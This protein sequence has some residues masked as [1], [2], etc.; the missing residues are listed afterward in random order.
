MANFIKMNADV[1]SENKQRW[2]TI[3]E[4]TPYPF[5][6]SQNCQSFRTQGQLIIL[7]EHP[8]TGRYSQSKINHNGTLRDFDRLSLLT[9][10]VRENESVRPKY[11]SCP[12]YQEHESCPTSNLFCSSCILKVKPLKGDVNQRETMIPWRGDSRYVMTSTEKER[13]KNLVSNL[14]EPQSEVHMS[15]FEQVRKGLHYVLGGFM[16]LL[17]ILWCGICPFPSLT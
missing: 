2:K 12:N 7:G 11:C 16:K 6:Q 5:H 9:V 1:F 8:S 10:K 17:W 15:F 4:R 13:W 3:E 14:F